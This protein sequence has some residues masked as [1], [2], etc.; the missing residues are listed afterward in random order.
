MPAPGA[1][2][3]A[4]AS[5]DLREMDELIGRG[6][7]PD[8]PDATGQTPLCYAVDSG[9][10]DL[11][12]RIL[13]TKAD[14]D[15]PGR[16]GYTPLMMTV[17]ASREDMT[18][19]LLAAGAD[20]DRVSDVLSSGNE[21]T[22]ASPLSV[23]INRGA[24]GIARRLF[25]AGANPERLRSVDDASYDPLNLP[26]LAVPADAG[27]WQDLGNIRDSASSPD[28]DYRGNGD[29][30]ALVRAA[31]DND[32]KAARDALDNG[33]NP[34]AA[35]ENGVTPL[36]AASWHGNASLVSLLLQRGADPVV[37]DNRGRGA[38]SYAAASGAANCIQLLLSV[39]ASIENFNSITPDDLD[40]SPLYYALIAENPVVFD[41]LLDAGIQPAGMDAGGMTLLMTAAWLGNLRAV[42]RLVPLTDAGV[43]DSEGRSAMAWAAAAFDR[44]RRAD[45]ADGIS[46]WATDYYPLIRLLSARTRNPAVYS[47]QPTR[48]MVFGNVNAAEAWQPGANPEWAAQL[49]KLNPSPV[50]MVPGDG[51]ITLYRIFRDEEPGIPA[52]N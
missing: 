37:N 42:A 19:R 20:P 52:G 36:M 40:Q 21:M 3:S 25:D 14:P 46:R 28:W 32:W 16:D 31:R 51:D 27:I 45:R 17:A 7:D 22:A 15:L 23:A 2:A 1:L 6:A 29:P 49:R 44:D 5:R 4:V 35:D 18:V 12:E 50:P 48:D 39:P 9:R 26:V 43:R 13:K 38:L 24:F 10:L 47:T 30:M 11:L 33:Y 8:Q 34:D 41:I